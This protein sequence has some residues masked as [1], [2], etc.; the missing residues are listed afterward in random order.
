MKIYTEVNYTWD[1]EKN[2]LVKES[3]KSFEYEGELALCWPNISMPT[4]KPPVITIPDIDLDPRTSDIN[5]GDGTLGQNLENIDLNPATSSVNPLDQP[6]L[7]QFGTG[8][9]GTMGKIT[10]GLSHVGGEINAG[11]N[12][13][14]SFM[15]YLGNKLSEF[16]YGSQKPSDVVVKNEKTA[17]GKD[18]QSAAELGTNKGA[19]RSRSSLKIS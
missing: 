19:Q 7:N 2:E 3:E 16:L 12:T 17:G 13:G 6:N 18:K 15:G 1:D 10:G 11:L 8:Q 5:L 4:W 9:G 14:L